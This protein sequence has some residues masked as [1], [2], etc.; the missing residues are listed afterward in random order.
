M[1]PMLNLNMKKLNLKPKHGYRKNVRKR[2]EVTILSAS[3][4]FISLKTHE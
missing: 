3:L 2:V 4:Y 1:E